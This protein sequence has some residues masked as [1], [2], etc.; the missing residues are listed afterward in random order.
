ME[1]GWKVEDLMTLF[2]MYNYGYVKNSNSILNEF[3]LL[4]FGIR[5]YMNQN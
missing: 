5:G 4:W 3:Y 2:S 1:E